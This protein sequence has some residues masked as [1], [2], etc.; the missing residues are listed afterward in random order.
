MLAWADGGGERPC[1]PETPQPRAL[2]S[3]V[4]RTAPRLRRTVTADG[5]SPSS[6]RAPRF[7]GSGQ[8]FRH[9]PRGAASPPDTSS[10]H[11]ALLP[12]HLRTVRGSVGATVVNAANPL[13][14]PRP[15]CRTTLHPCSRF[16]RSSRV[17]LTFENRSERSRRCSP[18]GSTTHERGAVKYPYLRHSAP[19]FRLFRTVLSS[20]FVRPAISAID[21][22]CPLS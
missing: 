1:W 18:Y 9:R 19:R 15:R 6:I 13:P 22:P 17:A 3:C 20:R 10:K 2:I 12:I 8:I 16:S 11:A 5:R 21:F 7:A 4:S 14:A